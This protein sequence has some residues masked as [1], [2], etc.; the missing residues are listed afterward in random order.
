MESPHSLR[1]AVIVRA[2]WM[3]ILMHPRRPSHLHSAAVSCKL[4]SVGRCRD[5]CRRFW[6]LF[7]RDSSPLSEVSDDEDAIMDVPG[8]LVVD[9]D[10]SFQFASK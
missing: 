2:V 8:L 5:R 6:L 9:N 7:A 1:S 4:L 3:S 10:V